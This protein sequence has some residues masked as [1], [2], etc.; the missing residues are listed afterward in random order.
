M[1][2]PLVQRMLDVIYRDPGVRRRC[3]DALTD[4]ILDTQPRRGGL[5]STR[6]VEYLAIHQPDLLSRLKMNVRLEDE[7]AQVLMWAAVSSFTS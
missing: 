1:S 7:L 3:K 5:D 4:W 2:E 6:L